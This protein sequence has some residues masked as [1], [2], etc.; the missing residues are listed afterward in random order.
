MTHHIGS[1]MGKRSAED[2]PGCTDFRI[3][4]LGKSSSAC[5]S[6]FTTNTAPH[7]GPTSICVVISRHVYFVFSPTVT[8]LINDQV[9]A[10]ISASTGPTLMAILKGCFL[11]KCDA[12]VT[13][14]TKYCTNFK[15]LFR[16]C[17]AQ[18]SPAS[19]TTRRVVTIGVKVRLAP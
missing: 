19:S 14:L 10:R 17:R 3:T 7:H 8:V 1:L 6:L 5:S 9:H 2:W 12:C 15:R 4:S 18:L 11:N 13:R 16:P